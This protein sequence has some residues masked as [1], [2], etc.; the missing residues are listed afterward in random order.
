MRVGSWRWLVAV[1]FSQTVLLARLT[2]VDGSSSRSSKATTAFLPRSIR[3]GAT[4]PEK[5]DEQKLEQDAI[6]DGT[7]SLSIL[8]A[9]AN[10]ATDA[11]D[12][13]IFVRKSDGSME[14]LQESKVSVENVD[15]CVLCPAHPI[16]H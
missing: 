16:S 7:P 4:R 6:T 2:V 13:T 10:N 8:R 3:G 9:N 15:N 1:L 12:E 5:A 11:D 14:P